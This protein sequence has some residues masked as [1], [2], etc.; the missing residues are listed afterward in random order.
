M[1]TVLFSFVGKC[2][3]CLCM[4]FFDQTKTRFNG[5][6]LSIVKGQ[7]VS[8]PQMT[9]LSSLMFK[10]DPRVKLVETVHSGSS[11]LDILI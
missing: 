5:C 2:N 4:I 1:L 8:R 6:F 3:S 10:N 9:S 11:N 7:K